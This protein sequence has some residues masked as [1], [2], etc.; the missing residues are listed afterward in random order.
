[1]K[2][3]LRN[4]K[5]LETV[6]K[7]RQRILERFPDAGLAQVAAEIIQITR[8]AI[9]R[10]EAISRPNLWIRGGQILLLLIAVAGV[11][12][13]TQT[14]TDQKPLLQTVLEFLDVTKGSA[15]ILA[16]TAIFLFT[17][18]TRLKRRRALQAVHELRAMAHLID[19]HQLTKDPDQLG[20]PTEPIIVGGQPMD[21]EAMGRYLHYCTELLAIVSKVGQLYVQDFPDT[22]AVAAVDQFEN[23][24]TGLSNK[25]WQKLMILGR[26]RSDAETSPANDPPATTLPALDPDPDR[27][28]MASRQSQDALPG[29]RESGLVPRRD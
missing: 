19:M 18:E 12:V 13:Y 27:N 22:A 7:I 23:L 16:A 26:I 10:A 3:Q 24:A 20:H 4:D 11:V 1:M 2:R 17:L 6:E 28:E 29:V 14:R 8:D 25:I 21:A 9:S 15:A 5:L